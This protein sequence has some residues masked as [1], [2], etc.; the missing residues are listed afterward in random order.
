MKDDMELLEYG[1]LKKTIVDLGTDHD[2]EQA[3][4]IY[5]LFNNISLSAYENMQILSKIQLVSITLAML[6]WG[7]CYPLINERIKIISNYTEVE[8]AQLDA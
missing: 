7:S 3:M 2:T 8:F 5:L 6:W 1:N 4:D